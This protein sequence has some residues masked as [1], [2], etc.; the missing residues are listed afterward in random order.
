MGVWHNHPLALEREL[1]GLGLRSRQVG[2]DELTWR[3]LQAIVSHA[4]PGGP[5]AKDLGYVWTTDGY[6]LANI[7]DALAGANWQRAG[8][9][10]E[11]PP[12][13]IKRPNEVMDGEKSFGFEPIPLSEFNDWWDS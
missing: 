2:T 11:P 1:I 7:Y 13:P 3:D 9:S 6:M 12:K 10:N 5:L 8:R 4:E